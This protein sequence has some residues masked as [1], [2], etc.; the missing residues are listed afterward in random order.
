MNPDDIKTIAARF[1]D[2]LLTDPVV[3]SETADALASR[4]P[5]EALARIASRVLK[6]EP[7]LDRGQGEQLEAELFD[8][9]ELLHRRH[10]LRKYVCYYSSAPE[11][12]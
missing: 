7:G 1:A 3:R 4:D 11:E 9:Y 6:L 12:D 2:V 5:A 10:K 8:I